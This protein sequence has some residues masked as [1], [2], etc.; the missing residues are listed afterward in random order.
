MPISSRLGANHQLPNS[1]ELF[2]FG[3][4]NRRSSPTNQKP[5]RSRDLFS[6]TQSTAPPFVC[7]RLH[8]T[9]SNLLH[10]VDLDRISHQLNTIGD[11]SKTDLAEEREAPL[12]LTYKGQTFT[13]KA[14]RAGIE[15]PDGF[16]ATPIAAAVRCY[17]QA[18][19]V[20]PSENGWQVWKS[21]D[22]RTLNT[23]FA[24]AADSADELPSDPSQD[25]SRL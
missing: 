9:A 10:Q 5:S 3:E 20:R 13:G 21:A 7:M 1:A 17:E 11:S 24:D 12:Y 18:G 6:P 23:I 16:N 2:S 19:T 8:Q 25:L 14:R 15:L 4:R 22:G